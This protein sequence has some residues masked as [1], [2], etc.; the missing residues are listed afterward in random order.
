MKRRKYLFLA[1]FVPILESCDNSLL[2]KENKYVFV[3][4]YCATITV[5]G[6]IGITEKCFSND[7]TI[8]GFE[9]TEGMITTRIAEHTYLNDKPPGPWSYQEFMNIPSEYLELLND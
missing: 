9:E 6:F 1:I 5:G 4:E 8:V 3:E 2:I 7:D